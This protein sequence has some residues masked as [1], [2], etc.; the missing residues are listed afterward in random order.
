MSKIGD[1]VNIKKC[2]NRQY[3]TKVSKVKRKQNEL[4]RNLYEDE[5]LDQ[6][7]NKATLMQIKEGSVYT[8]T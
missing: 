7:E 2:P 8:A 5:P 6:W 3:R 4:E 1:N